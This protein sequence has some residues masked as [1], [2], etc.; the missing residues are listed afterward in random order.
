MKIGLLINC[1]VIYSI[2]IYLIVNCTTLFA[3]APDSPEIADSDE[4]KST[5]SSF[6]FEGMRFGTNIKVFKQRFPNAK[7][8]SDLSYPSNGLQVFTVI[9]ETDGSVVAVFFQDDALRQVVFFFNEE[10]IDKINDKNY[11]GDIV[12][13]NRALASFGLP[14]EKYEPDDGGVHYSWIFEDINK[15]VGLDFS[16]NSI[17]KIKL[18]FLDT[19]DIIKKRSDRTYTELPPR[20]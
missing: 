7:F 4:A 1:R 2:C 10:A 13:L 17:I 19:T 9:I 3:E 5:I 6:E 18:T 15:Y 11:G 20:T 8:N 16:P 14:D 12:I